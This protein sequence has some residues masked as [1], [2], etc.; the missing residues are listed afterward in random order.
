M[1]MKL[2]RQFRFIIYPLTDSGLGME[3]GL[4]LGFFPPSFNPHRLRHVLSE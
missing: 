2:Y 4:L 3:Y 1:V